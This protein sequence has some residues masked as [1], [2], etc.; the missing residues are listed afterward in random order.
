[1]TLNGRVIVAMQEEI[2]TMPPRAAE[3]LGAELL[4]IS[5]VPC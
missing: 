5:L 1:M 3:R 4:N 2:A